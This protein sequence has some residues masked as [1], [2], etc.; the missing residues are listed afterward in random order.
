MQLG[1]GASCEEELSGVF[2][3]VAVV[4]KGCKKPFNR[5]SCFDAPIVLP[6]SEVPSSSSSRGAKNSFLDTR[7]SKYR[8]IATTFL[9][10][11]FEELFLA[12]TRSFNE[13]GSN[14]V[15]ALS[16]VHS[17]TGPRWTTLAGPPKSVL[18]KSERSLQ[19]TRPWFCHA[20]ILRPNLKAMFSL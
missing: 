12:A 4:G 11:L 1:S 18:T 15:G 5:S 7:F 20:T 10:F 17:Q 19:I 16:D 6:F 14:P 2:L 8:N 9:I 13:L 3:I